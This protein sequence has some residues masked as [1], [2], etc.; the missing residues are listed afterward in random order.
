MRPILIPALVLAIA[1]NATLAGQPA[2]DASTHDRDVNTAGTGP[3]RLVVDGALLAVASPFRVVI[4]GER[5]VAESG[6]SDLR[7][8]THQG[9]PVPYLLIHPAG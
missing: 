4:R 3:Q 7:L 6:L 5:R 9:T 2:S 1:A 8:F